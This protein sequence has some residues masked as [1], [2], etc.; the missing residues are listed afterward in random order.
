M[1][2]RS[3]II[4]ASI[5]AVL[6]LIAAFSYGFRTRG[7]ALYENK[8][9]IAQAGPDIPDIAKLARPTGSPAI[10]SD[11][12]VVPGYTLEDVKRFVGTHPIRTNDGQPRAFTISRAEFMNSK[13]VSDVL[14]GASTGFADDY[15]LCYVELAGIFIF[16][17]PRGATRTYKRGFEV[18]DAQTGNLLMVGGLRS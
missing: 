2:A 5:V 15:M 8:N 10:K 7:V 17:G 18:F 6:L 13:Q 16:S 9:A 3:Q 4:I 12:A 11:T 1:N 14:N